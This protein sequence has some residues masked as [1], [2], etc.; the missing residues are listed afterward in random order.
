VNERVVNGSTVLPD[1]IRYATYFN[2]DRDSINTALFEER[3]KVMKERN[4]SVEDSVL[5]FSDNVFIQDGAKKYV[6]L[7][8]CQSFWENCGEDSVKLGQGQGRMDPL[9]KLYIGCRLMLTRNMRVRQGQANGTQVTLEKVV[10]KNGMEPGEVMISGSI[11]VAAVRASEVSYLVLRHANERIQ[12]P[13]F[14]LFPKEHTFKANLLKPRALQVKG[15]D[16]EMVKMKA[17]QVPIVVN[18]A[19]TGHKLQGSGVDCLFVHNWSYVTNWV[20]VM[21]SRVKTRGGLYCRKPICTDVSKYAVPQALQRML[22]QFAEKLPTFWSEEEYDV[23]FE[24]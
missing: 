14:M 21:L 1:N 23:I 20:Y 16:R 7:R 13:T 15:N 3:C 19:T 18:N 11:P 2:R 12:P 9:L 24:L 6:R 10:L 5:I 17:T 4:G 22:R 8:N